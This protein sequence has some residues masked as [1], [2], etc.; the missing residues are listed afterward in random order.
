MFNIFKRKKTLQT[1]KS[2]V[3]TEPY[4]GVRDFYPEDMAIQ[5]YIFNVWKKTAE[6]FGYQEYNTSIL[7]YADLFKEKSG[8]EI[9]NEQTYTFIDRGDREVTL[10]PEIT[11]SVARMIAAKRKAWAFPVRWYA[12]A[13]CFRY[14]KPQRGRLRD[15]FQ[16]NADI[17]GIEDIQAD[18]EMISLAYQTMKNFGLKD[19]Q[20]E[21]KIN[22]GVN[23]TKKDAETL[24]EKLN[25]IGIKNTTFD[26]GIIRGMEYYTGIVFE[27][28]DTG[29]EN[30]RA[31]FGGGRYDNLLDIF[32]VEKVPAVGFGMGDVI[33]RDILETYN[34]LPE[35]KSVSK[36]YIC[37]MDEK[38]INYAQNLA[39]KIREKGINTS[40]DYSGKK[41]GDQIKYADKNKIPFVVVIGDEEVKTGKFKIKELFS[42]NETETT[43]NEIASI[44][45]K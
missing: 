26:E 12:I 13:D 27:I 9:I 1:G 20:F 21:I 7:E 4:K 5:N 14:E 37:V 28:Y 44:L 34:L 38:F 17:F 16:F 15:F 22:V 33:M 18:I 32:G 24:M 30:S 25:V 3:G 2:K 40:V 41:I 31:I 39:Q 45:N 19:D 35:S 11:P 43:E 8:A 23:A 36:L 6:S 10:R 29:K 42:G